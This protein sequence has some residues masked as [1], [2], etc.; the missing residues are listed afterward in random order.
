MSRAVCY[1]TGTLVPGS[2]VITT[3]LFLARGGFND[4]LQSGASQTILESTEASSETWDRLANRFGRVSEKERGPVQG[5]KWRILEA[6]S[7]RS[8]AEKQLLGGAGK[9][10]DGMVSRYLN[11]PISRWITLRLLPFPISP[12]AWTISI[13]IFPVLSFLFLVRGDY[14][15][16]LIGTL[17]YHVHSILDG[18]DGEIARAKYLESK[19]GGRI[20][21]YCDIFGCFLFVIGLGLGLYAHSTGTHAWLYAAEGF[22]CAIFMAANEWLLRRPAKEAELESD[23][24]TQ[25]VYPRHRQLIQRSGLAFLGEN[26]VWWLVQITKRDVGILFFVLLAL[27]GQAQWILHLSFAVAAVTLTLS[28]V[29]RFAPAGARSVSF[30]AS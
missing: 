7:D 5:S 11:R 27:I 17:L 4:F 8:A 26:A 24:L 3:H 10:Q 16:L 25:A 20:D 2:F 13:F 22:L 18:C 9:P 21:D 6:K 1:R 14:A 30:G 23:V 19:R 28:G 29:A 12:T 15:G